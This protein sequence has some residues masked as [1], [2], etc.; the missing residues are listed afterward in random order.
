MTAWYAG[1][2]A[3]IVTALGWFL[4][5]SLHSTLNENAQ[6]A[7]EL[8]YRV[9]ADRLR[10]P[11]TDLAAILRDA[12]LPGETA[13]TEVIG[14][15]LDR[16][17]NVVE[18]YGP[19]V[20]DGRV[21][22]RTVLDEVVR[23]GHWHGPVQIP[24]RAHDDI[25]VVARLSGGVR[26][27]SF[28]V[29]AQTLGPSEHA[30]GRLAWLLVVATPA[31]LTV[32]AIGGWFVASVA[33]RPVDAM[34]RRAAGIDAARAD[35]RL[36]VPPADDELSRL[37]STLN[38]MLERL[39]RALDA[40]RR[41]SADASHEL[42]TPIG[43]IEAE[44]DVAL[45]S[46]ATPPEA[47]SVLSSVREEAARLGRIVGNLLVLSR[48]EAAGTV[49]LDCRPVDLLDL[50]VPVAA[51]LANVAADRGVELRVAGE[52]ATA[53]VDA[54]LLGQAVANLL[55]NA[56]SHTPRGG[57]VSVTVS[58]GAEPTLA[59]CDTGAGIPADELPRIFDRFYRVDRARGRGGAGLGLEICRRI[60]EAHGGRIDVE[61][62][63]GAGSTFRIRLRVAGG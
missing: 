42:R 5:T 36:P 31:A 63:P 58:G 20:V 50:A 1:V 13:E 38:G 23:A 61:S 35:E 29:L 57:A 19:R 34:T 15:I 51:R 27:G 28:L 60:V 4:V 18:A 53:E 8:T 49:A 21:I 59:V 39:R 54:D 44:V 37:A 47:R 2:F 41:F 52:A 55:D 46:P 40:E 17:G 6:E 43:L 24:G 62:E 22:D 11:D 10:E 32:A 3:L 12:V 56:L 7:L 26:T 30:A 9:V 25:A 48:A 33:L 45:R 14:Q 16:E